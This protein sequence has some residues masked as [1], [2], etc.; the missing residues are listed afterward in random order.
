M[1]SIVLASSRFIMIEAC[2]FISCDTEIHNSGEHARV[3]QVDLVA[4]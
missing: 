1:E 3:V 4:V 2:L